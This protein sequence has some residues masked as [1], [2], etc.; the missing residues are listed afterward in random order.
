MAVE[1]GYGD[2]RYP[3]RI[4]KVGYG[5]PNLGLF[6]QESCA[7]QSLQLTQTRRSSFTLSLSIPIR[8]TAPLNT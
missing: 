2:F 1:A 3:K 7:G 8:A 6:A 4:G 5:H